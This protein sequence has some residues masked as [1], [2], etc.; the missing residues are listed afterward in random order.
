MS[1]RAHSR[2]IMLT[3]FMQGYSTGKPCSPAWYLT[4]ATH[5]RRSPSAKAQLGCQWLPTVMLKR[6]PK[7]GFMG[8]GF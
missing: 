3:A 2:M 6:R 5:P 7:G 8:I 1:M 4:M